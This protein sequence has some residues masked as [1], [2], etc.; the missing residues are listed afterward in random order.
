MKKG[1]LLVTGAL[2]LFSMDLFAKVPDWGDIITQPPKDC[3]RAGY[4]CVL[5]VVNG[6]AFWCQKTARDRFQN[7]RKTFRVAKR[8]RC[9]R[10]YAVERKEPPKPEGE[11]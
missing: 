8:I 2:I 1:I 10:R 5:K 11:E 3:R 7:A 4:T 6:E 9:V